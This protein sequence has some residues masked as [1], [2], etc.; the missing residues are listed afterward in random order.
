[1][2]LGLGSIKRDSYFLIDHVSYNNLLCLHGECVL[3][4]SDVAYYEHL[5]DIEHAH[6]FHNKSV[7][8]CSQ[9]YKLGLSQTE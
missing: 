1:M 5:L 3:L 7:S 2:V 4:C 8:L 9:P 6:T